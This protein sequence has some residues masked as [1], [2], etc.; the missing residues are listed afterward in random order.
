M[1]LKLLLNEKTTAENYQTT[2]L[3]KSNEF[4]SAMELKKGSDI[5]RNI[6]YLHKVKA[7]LKGSRYR[8]EIRVNFFQEELPFMHDICA[9]KKV[10]FWDFSGFPKGILDLVNYESCEN[11]GSCNLVIPTL[12]LVR[13]PKPKEDVT[14]KILFE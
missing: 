14:F 11:L 13:D 10:V 2:L 7:D 9:V 5:F 1:F 3:T 6:F 12:N 8:S 4:H